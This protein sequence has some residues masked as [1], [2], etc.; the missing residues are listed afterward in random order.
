M[1]KNYITIL[2]HNTT[3]WKANKYN[4]YNVY[5]QHDPD[6]ILLNETGVKDI[7]E[8]KIFQYICYKTNHSNET[9]DGVAIA[10]KKNLKHKLLKVDSN[11]CICIQLETSLGPINIA[12]T[13][14]PP[15]RPYFPYIELRNLFNRQEPTYLIADLNAT[16]PMFGNRTTNPKGQALV[17]MIN[18]GSIQWHGPP[19]KTWFGNTSST[20]DKILSNNKVYHNINIEKGLPCTNDHIPILIKISTSP[21]AIPVPP[22]YDI[23]NTNWEIYREELSSYSSTD[24][25]KASTASI[26]EEL[27]KVT[28]VISDAIE[29][30]T[31]LIKH[32]ILPAP[33]LPHE[34]KLLQVQYSNLLEFASR[35]QV[36]PPQMQ[37]EIT[38]VRQQLRETLKVY[39]SN[40]WNKLLTKIKTS[41]A[42][43][44]W[45][46]I[47]RLLGHDSAK[48]PYI[49]NRDGRKLETDQ[50]IANEFKDILKNV[51]KDENNPNC[52]F[53]EQF[54]AEVNVYL[55]ENVDRLKS[56]NNSNDA[57]FDDQ[58]IKE[59]S[60][61]EL[62]QY[63][64]KMA[65]RAPGKSGIM[66]IHLKEA[67][68]LV[69]QGYCGIFNAC[70]T[71]GYFPTGFKTASIKMINKPGKSAT[72]ST[73]YR[74]ISLLE[75]P[76]KLFEKIINDRLLQH[77][78]LNGFLNSQ[79]FGFR[80]KR[81]TLH[82]IA[83]ATE[84]I[85]M[86]LSTKSRTTIVLRDVSKAFDKVW[87]GGLRYK[88][89]HSQL[90]S[91]MEKLLSSLLGERRAYISHGNAK[92]DT[93]SLETGV[94]QGGC[95]SPTLYIFYCHDIPPRVYPCNEDIQFADDVTQI[96]TTQG[97]SQNFHAKHI[98]KEIERINAFERKWRISTNQNKFKVIPIN[99]R[100]NARPQ[101]VINGQQHEMSN[102]GNFLGL[103]IS[104]TGYS[105]HVTTKAKRARQQ[106]TKLRR[107]CD[108]TEKTKRQLYLTLIRP[109]LE[110]PP[111]PLHT[112]TSNSIKKLQI[113]QNDATR[114]ITNIR[115]PDMIR[116][117]ILHNRCN[118]QPLNQLLFRR[119]ENI[120]HA[121][122][123]EN[124]P[125]MQRL[126]DQYN[127]GKTYTQFPSSLNAI[128]RRL[129]Q[130]MF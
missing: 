2:Q 66:Q 23:K 13:Y 40:L 22:R 11:N 128:K 21:I 55:H 74:P 25:R 28:K 62:T 1:A 82:A 42:K 92:S 72:F 49:V 46:Q 12:T 8:I 96:I 93:F 90:P 87:H 68:D 9:H 102:S 100:I 97:H 77:W 130:P 103:E 18:S 17:Q 106:L 6:I 47:N 98:K 61:V 20:P 41:D 35:L 57:R 116:S 80:P 51:F 26:E 111:I 70:L 109:I 120:W 52:D 81:G 27:T 45:T 60:T 94:A 36:I 50:D 124:Y 105:K 44:F 88:I 122:E 14:L 104:T 121:I 15:R 33:K 75:V 127:G 114:F 79:Q 123:N 5:R 115:Y 19:F 67:T 10:I 34:V 91:C 24:L 59:I 125:M 63:I 129:P 73:N 54:K 71:A 112:L 48:A 53:D 126:L 76:G 43:E 56:Y 95:I 65:N 30:S 3:S 31:P 69:R 99:N 113:V 117:E 78:T 39:S 4:H 83:L 85:S 7:E 101:L 64:S 86:N 16:H 84:K 29:K 110:Y 32:R 108:L 38:N 58:L 89:L 37:H 107:F 118:L 119:A